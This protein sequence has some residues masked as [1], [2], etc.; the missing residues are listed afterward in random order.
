ML[1]VYSENQDHG[2]GQ[3]GTFSDG[4]YYSNQ[5]FQAVIG[6]RRQIQKCHGRFLK[7]NGRI[8]TFWEKVC[9]WGSRASTSKYNRCLLFKKFGLLVDSYTIHIRGRTSVDVLGLGQETGSGAPFHCVIAP[10]VSQRLSQGK[11]ILA[12]TPVLES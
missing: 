9:H 1:P 5:M 12:A 6:R 8:P 4:S 3:P 2:D 7:V 11:G 10:E